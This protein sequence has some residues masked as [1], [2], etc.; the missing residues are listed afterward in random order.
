MYIALSL[1]PGCK[2]PWKI[3]DLKQLQVVDNY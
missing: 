3:E 1:E 2:K